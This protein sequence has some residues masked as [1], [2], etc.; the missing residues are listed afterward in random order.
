MSKSGNNG[1]AAIKAFLRCS[2]CCR[3]AN[4]SVGTCRSKC[5][6][7]SAALTPCAFLNGI[8]V[9]CSIILKVFRLVP[10]VVPVIS[11]CAGLH[12]AEDDVLNARRDCAFVNAITIRVLHIE[13]LIAA[14]PSVQCETSI[15]LL[16]VCIGG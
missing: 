4:V 10:F 15:T 16:P 9:A 3:R 2:T 1:I 13:P 8:M 6:P 7:G 12:T 14:I 11:S 5:A